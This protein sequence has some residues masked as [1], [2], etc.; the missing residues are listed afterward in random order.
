[1]LDLFNSWVSF[2]LAMVIAWAVMSK[3]VKDGVIVKFGLI[4]LSVGFLV[5]WMITLQSGYKNS[6]ALESVH[7]LIY[8]GLA[9]C[10]GGYLW[11]TRCNGK[12]RRATD[13]IVK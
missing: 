7:C 12:E 9:I 13:W 5:A 6:D 2:L 11:R 1:M 10:V 3:H 4:C 8:V